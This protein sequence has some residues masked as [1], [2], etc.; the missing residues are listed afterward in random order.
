MPGPAPIPT[1]SMVH[2]ALW[3]PRAPFGT[4]S[5]PPGCPRVA[6]LVHGP[7]L[8]R[9]WWR[10][11]TSSPP[12]KEKS[13]IRIF[14][15]GRGKHTICLSHHTPLN[16]HKYINESAQQQKSKALVHCPLVRAC[17]Y[18][19]GTHGIDCSFWTSSLPANLIVL[20]ARVSLSWAYARTN[21]IVFASQAINTVYWTRDLRV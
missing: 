11:D 1:L 4:Q 19:T 6:H 12:Y 5:P 9:G 20:W 18:W 2:S 3:R 10:A 8:H 21:N 15:S 16:F 13:L 17:P 7:C 14:K